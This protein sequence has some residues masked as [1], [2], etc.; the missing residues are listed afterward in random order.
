MSSAFRSLRVCLGVLVG[1]SLVFHWQAIPLHAEELSAEVR[2]RLHEATVMVETYY[3]R[4]DQTPEKRVGP[5]T[6]S[7]LVIAAEGLILTNAHCVASVL[8]L[9]V[10]S[11]NEATDTARPEDRV[12]LVLDSVSVRLRSGKRETQVFSAQVL[13]NRP[14]PV[15]LALL[16]IRPEVPLACLDLLPAADFVRLRETEPVWAIGFP[17]GLDIEEILGGMPKL[18]KNP[19]G[20]DLEFRDGTI[21]SLR[22]DELQKVKVVGTTCL[23]EPGNSGGPLV[24]RRGRVIGINY[25][26]A[27]RGFS[28]SIPVALALA[29]FA[30]TLAARH[31]AP[32][33]AAADRKVVLLY[34]IVHEGFYRLPFTLAEP[35]PDPNRWS[36]AVVSTAIY[37]VLA[38][39]QPG[40]TIHI[41]AGEFHLDKPLVLPKGVWLRGAGVGKTKLVLTTPAA[42]VRVDQPGYVE[43][44]DLT[45]VGFGSDQ[46]NSWKVGL[47]I[48]P[49]AGRETYVHDIEVIS[50]ANQASGLRIDGGSSANVIA[51]KVPLVGGSGIPYQPAVI[52]RGSMGTPRLERC[53]FSGYS[54]G[55]EID[56]GARPIV[57]GCRIEVGCGI[58]ARSGAAP[59]VTGCLFQCTGL[60]DFGIVDVSAA[61][62]TFSGNSFRNPGEDPFGGTR[63]LKISSGAKVVFTGNQFLKLGYRGFRVGAPPLPGKAV[64]LTGSDTRAVFS[65]NHFDGCEYALEGGAQVEVAHPNRTIDTLKF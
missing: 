12:V 65:G 26:I 51:C 62:G 55:M 19:Y 35:K 57:E 30:E 22:R 50:R 41:P 21:S 28:F 3:R 29:E 23:I 20:P 8:Q 2:A 14:L 36:A 47:E 42:T 10:R 17:K 27:G 58:L 40:D 32:G 33:S 7:G 18:G 15:D 43:I 38:N 6:G 31:P 16:R 11:G 37:H 4:I 60:P 63:P 52:V 39:P 54:I 61:Q 59:S 53:Q 9:D 24:D 49:Q 25:L 56:T 64:Q 45:I 44:S 46:A 1:V 5:F 34:D 13:A 48:G